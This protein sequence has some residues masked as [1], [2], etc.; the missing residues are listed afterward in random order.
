MLRSFAWVA[1]IALFACPGVMAETPDFRLFGSVGNETHLT[2]GNPS[3]RLNPGDF[4]N[5]P[6]VSNSLDFNLFTDVVPED[7]SWKF[8]LKLRG[9]NDWNRDNSVSKIEVGEL[10]YSVSLASWLDV[11]AGRSIERWGTGY[12]WNPTGVVNPRKNPSDPTD[13]RDRYQGVDNVQ[14]DLFVRDWNVTLLAVPEID[15]D[16]RD[17]K[18][19][20]STGWAVRAYRLVQGIDLSLSASG[21]NGL[22]N[23]Q[24]VS[25]S[26][27]VGNALEIHAE[28]A[29]FQ[30]S[31]RFRP[32]DGGWM[33]QTKKHVD[34]LLGGQYTFP[35]NVNVVVEYYHSGNGL[36]SVEWTGYQHMVTGAGQELI[37]GNPVP[38]LIDNLYYSVLTMARDYAF[39]RFYWLFHH[40][41]LEAEV[42]VLAN[43]RDGSS[44]LRPGIY[45]KI[46]PNWSLYWLQSELLGG[47]STEF[48][49]LQV[50]RVSDFGVR[51]HF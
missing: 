12:A 34:L 48:G 19:L 23:S 35:R 3:S 15:W 36:D 10:N 25:V 30:D 20:L 41:K 37:S 50:S 45:W 46:H 43:L 22:P 39:G 49:H 1:F 14:V 11:Q 47:A 6:T 40:D 27:V 24:G 44:L 26:R 51:Y 7:K 16:G 38:L 4:L 32:I 42:L 18:H 8:H 5:I 21:G 17:G 9:A 29:A 2:P 13:R 31:V 28:I 33:P